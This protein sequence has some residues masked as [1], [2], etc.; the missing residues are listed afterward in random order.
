MIY[1]KTDVC[2][3]S[4]FI[5]SFIDENSMNAPLSALGS[6]LGSNARS[7]TSIMPADIKETKDALEFAI[8]APGVKKDDVKVEVRQEPN[9]M[10][11]L[12]IFLERKSTNTKDTET[13]HRTERYH[14]KTHR[15]FHLPSEVKDEE[16][17]AKID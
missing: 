14:G 9:G 6:M 3:L 15:W 12:H 7:Q 1:K 16:V 4:Y 2:V 8:D 13:T 17:S 10:K 11:L 5:R